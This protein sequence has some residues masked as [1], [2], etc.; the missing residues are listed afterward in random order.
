MAASGKLGQRR[1]E[2]ASA[3]SRTIAP[4][5]TALFNVQKEWKEPPP[6]SL[7]CRLPLAAR[8]ARLAGPAP[9]GQRAPAHLAKRAPAAPGAQRAQ[10]LRPFVSFSFERA[11]DAHQH[12]QRGRLEV[13]EFQA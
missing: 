8:L 3:V 4:N 5:S 6:I 9:A 10:V 12:A 2:A 1:V 11:E 13:Q 7:A